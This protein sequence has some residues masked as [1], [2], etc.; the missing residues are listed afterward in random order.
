M[1]ACR[2]RLQCSAVGCFIDRS[3]LH[4]R[5]HTTLRTSSSGSPTRNN[6]QT[7]CREW[8]PPVRIRYT[9]NTGRAQQRNTDAATGSAVSSRI[10]PDPN[11]RSASSSRLSRARVNRYRPLMMSELD[12]DHESAAKL[13][14]AR[15][16]AHHLPGRRR[17][18]GPFKT[19][20]HPIGARNARSG[21]NVFR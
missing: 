13:G 18:G 8:S 19:G 5:L 11:N 20:F 1:P 15:K 6:P 17:H 4:S 9:R 3:S 12:L 21:Q 14:D 16:T 7:S 2:R 10:H